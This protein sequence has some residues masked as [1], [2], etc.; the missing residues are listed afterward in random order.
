[1]DGGLPQPR[2]GRQT[3]ENK[4]TPATP[5]SAGARSPAARGG[6]QRERARALMERARRGRQDGQLFSDK[7]ARE[8]RFEQ[9]PVR[10]AGAGLVEPPGR[11]RMSVTVTRFAYS[12]I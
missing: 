2:E 6:S 1:M 12:S 5:R 11:D 7:E 10:S 3:A 4:R 9:E 8:V